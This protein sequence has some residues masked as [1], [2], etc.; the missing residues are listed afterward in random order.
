MAHGDYTGQQKS[1]LAKRFAQEQQLAAKSTALVTQ[2]VTESRDDVIN[3]FVDRDWDNLQ[4]DQVGEG[5]GVTEV[6]VQDPL[7]QAVKFRASEDLDEVTV[8]QDRQF[9]LE[10]GRVYEAPK[11]VVEHLD[12]Q[13]L[14]YH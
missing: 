6:G 8:G 4:R 1:A 2:V 14:V 3:L 7:F 11:W 9:T 12:V 10:A 13:G 5:D